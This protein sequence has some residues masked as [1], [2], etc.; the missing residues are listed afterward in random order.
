[1]KKFIMSVVL[2]V[3]ILF[4]PSTSQAYLLDNVQQ[5]NGH[6]YKVFNYSMRWNDAKD[7]CE[8]LGGH[9]VTI[10]SQMEQNFIE[11]LI[12]SN[13]K[14]SYWI[15]GYKSQNSNWAW[16]TGEQF[17]YSKWAQGEPNNGLGMYVED[18]I[19]IYNYPNANNAPFGTWND[20]MELGDTKSYGFICEWDYPN[21][22]KVRY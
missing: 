5:F 13:E 6:Y 7:F 16:V 8:N 2:S 1:M 17:N 19:N 4:L 14:G 9:L 10:T 3:S 11:T 12:K 20:A 21:S 15:G 18:K 22:I